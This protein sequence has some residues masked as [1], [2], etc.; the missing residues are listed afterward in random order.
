MKI[1][2]TG[3]AGFI[4]TNLIARLLTDPF[5]ESEITL[6]DN[7][8]RKG[9]EQNLAYLKRLAYAKARPLRLFIQDV[10]CP[11]LMPEAMEG[12]D[13]VFHL[14]AQ[15]AV[16]TSIRAPLRDFRDNALGTL[17]VLETARAQ[18][19]PPIL[20]Y[21]STNKVYGELA[22]H[23]S[24][25]VRDHYAFGPHAPHDVDE[26]T[27][28]DF[29]SPYGCSKG[30]ADQYVRDYARIYGMDTIVFRMSCIYGP[31]QNGTEDQGW[32][33]HIM[34]C[35]IE[36]RMIDVFG[37]GAQVR[38]I[39]YVDDLVRAMVD[40]VIMDP[41][42]RAILPRVFNVGGGI[43]NVISVNGLIA[44]LQDVLNKRLQVSYHDWRPGDQ[45]VYI[46]DIRR[47]A[48]VFGFTPRMDATDGLQALLRWMT[49]GEVT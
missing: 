10:I 28:L 24:M 34:R 31:R 33:A 15:V 29:H 23:T 46:S 6:Y 7:L 42:R 35:A 22:G 1:L 19:K 40:V 21:T 45:K 26:L 39:L 9:S 37:D 41:R 20:L 43:K 25:M 18:P 48:Q 49:T 2:V 11:T 36:D 27:P 32:I 13:V 17:R 16:T 38:D 12:I 44:W 4:G 47:A 5:G 14:A 3:G 8:S 30:A